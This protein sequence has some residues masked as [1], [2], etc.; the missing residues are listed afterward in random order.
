MP[1]EGRCH[2]SPSSSWLIFTTTCEIRKNTSSRIS[3]ERKPKHKGK[4]AVS[5]RSQRQAR[6]G[7]RAQCSRGLCTALTALLPADAAFLAREKAKADAECYTAMKL[8]EA[9]KVKPRAAGGGEGLFGLG[10]MFESSRGPMATTTKVPSGQ[11]GWPLCCGGQV[12]PMP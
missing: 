11:K 4:R 2:P 1:T 12:L 10:L 6:E 5:A 9:N 8:A 3:Q 7:P